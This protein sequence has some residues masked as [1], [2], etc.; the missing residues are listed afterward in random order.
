MVKKW[1]FCSR[2][3]Q[4]QQFR[5]YLS[6]YGV[7]KSYKTHLGDVALILLYLLNFSPCLC[8]KY[9]CGDQCGA[10]G[11]QSGHYTC[12]PSCL[13]CNFSQN[14]GEFFLGHVNF[15]HTYENI[16]AKILSIRILRALHVS[17]HDP[18]AHIKHPMCS[19]CV[20]VRIYTLT[21]KYTPTRRGVKNTE[22]TRQ[23]FYLCFCSKQP[24]W[25]SDK[26]SA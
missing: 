20:C 10:L 6:W 14:R 1:P 22:D 8:A 19:V 15:V 12:R 25:P 21:P 26:C 16:F 24:P 13:S 5:R 18:W 4:N 9:K 7:E 11:V 2:C 3:E 17:C 23:H